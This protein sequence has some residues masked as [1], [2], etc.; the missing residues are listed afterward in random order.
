MS[1]I[2]YYYIFSIAKIYHIS[3][4]IRKGLIFIGDKK[5]KNIP[6]ATVTGNGWD[7]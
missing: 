5:M 1:Y 7:N 2:I 4:P 6:N 3:I